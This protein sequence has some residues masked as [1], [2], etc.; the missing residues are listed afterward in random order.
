MGR[1]AVPGGADRARLRRGT[2]STGSRRMLRRSPERKDDTAP[3][4]RPDVRPGGDQRRQSFDGA[5]MRPSRPSLPSSPA[6]SQMLG[7][8]LLPHGKRRTDGSPAMPTALGRNRCS[9]R[10]T[11]RRSLARPATASTRKVAKPGRRIEEG[12]LRS[13]RREPDDEER[14]KCR[15]TRGNSSCP[16]ASSNS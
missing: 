1:S 14:R 3:R 8:D 10:S 11:E 7:G 4:G 16:P 15:Q 6:S 9:R 5:S 13:R 2:A 12:E